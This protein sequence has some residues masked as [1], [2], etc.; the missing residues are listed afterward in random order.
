MYLSSVSSSYGEGGVTEGGSSEDLSE[1]EDEEMDIEETETRRQRRRSMRRAPAASSYATSIA[2]RYPRYPGYP[3]PATSF[4]RSSQ[5][6][7]GLYRSPAWER[8]AT[9]GVGQTQQWSRY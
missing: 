5:G 4:P 3:N 2:S 9:T 6:P 8:S 1:D 7:L